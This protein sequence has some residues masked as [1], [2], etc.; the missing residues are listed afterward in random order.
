MYYL[1]E[2]AK[3]GLET[4]RRLRIWLEAEEDHKQRTK[5]ANR[6]IIKS[7]PD[8]HACEKY[9]VSCPLEI[10]NQAVVRSRKE[11]KQNAF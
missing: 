9:A 10:W 6:I 1:R 3:L 5:P 7:D 11:M 2:A 8:R 4:G